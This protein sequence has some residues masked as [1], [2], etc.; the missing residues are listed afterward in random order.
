MKPN[1]SAH[2]V[3]QGDGAVRVSDNETRTTEEQP[4]PHQQEGLATFT[5]N[6]N[7]YEEGACLS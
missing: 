1:P 3:K 7:D 2:A 5:T 4:P 6:C